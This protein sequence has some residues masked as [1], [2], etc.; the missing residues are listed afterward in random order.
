[1]KTIFLSLF[2]LCCW[3]IPAKAQP[4]G[5]SRGGAEA[6]M[7]Q[8]KL[9][10]T[11]SFLFS[12]GSLN[13][14]GDQ[15]NNKPAVLSAL[16]ESDKVIT[17]FEQK[18][19][20]FI[21]S[22]PVAAVLKSSYA[23]VVSTAKRA[24]VAIEQAARA[25]K[26]Y[27]VMSAVSFLQELY[28]YKAYI[29]A[30]MKVYPEALSMQEQLDAVE[31]A[32][33]SQGSR[34]DYIALMEKNQLDYVKG[35][36]MKKAVASDPGIEKMVKSS[37]ET[38]WAADK[39]TVV[40]VHIVSAWTIEKNVLDIPLHKELEV[41]MAI[42]KADGSCALAAGYVRAEYEGGGKYGAPFLLMPTPPTTVPCENIPSP[43][44]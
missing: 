34:E 8:M 43:T 18:V 10:F 1:M 3:I 17:E 31:A 16:S 24:A 36:R 35:L 33:Q 32:I 6:T 9:L 27:R 4:S 22:K 29:A 13:I 37:Y 14:P 39:L 12:K 7:K 23:S 15:A 2:S 5:Y 40:K 28:L 20:A 21:Q 44:K 25:K 38:S 19:D 41:N 26:E 11:E 42:K 30:A